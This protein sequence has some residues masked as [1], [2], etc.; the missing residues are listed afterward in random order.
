[1]APDAGDRHGVGAGRLAGHGGPDTAALLI[2]YLARTYPKPA[3]AALG[4]D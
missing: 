1:M 2:D 4:G 3:A